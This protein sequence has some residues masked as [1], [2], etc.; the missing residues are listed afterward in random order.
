[1]LSLRMT[2]EISAARTPPPNALR[3]GSCPIV[4]VGGLPWEVSLCLGLLRA[5]PWA[6]SSDCLTRVWQHQ[7]CRSH[8]LVIPWVSF[9]ILVASWD[10]IHNARQIFRM[11]EGLDK[12]GT[13]PHILGELH[14]QITARSFTPSSAWHQR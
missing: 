14:P 10:N 12:M 13:S 9:V 11:N 6:G 8:S 1:M 7:I 2:S 3:P 5:A 4:R